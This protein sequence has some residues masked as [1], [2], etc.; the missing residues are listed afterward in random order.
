MKTNR[1]II[2]FAAILF[3]SF[4]TGNA[5]AFRCGSDVVGS[6]DSKSHAPCGHV[7]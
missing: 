6:G 4:S 7:G 1:T 2:F 5:W 3:L